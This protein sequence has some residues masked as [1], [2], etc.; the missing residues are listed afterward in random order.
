MNFNN[1]KT[2]LLKI[3]S[4]YED[5]ELYAK[6]EGCNLAGSIKDRAAQNVLSKLIESGILKENGTVI[7]SSSGNMGIALALY[8]NKFRLNFYCVVDPNINKNN[9]K[10][11]RLLGAHIIMVDEA[12]EHGGYLINRI[13][14]VK[15]FIEKNQ[16]AYWVNQYD[17]LLIIEGY[18]CIADEIIEDIK[19]LDYLFMTISSAG[20]IAGISRRIKQLSPNTKVVCVDVNGSV[21]FRN[22]AKKRYIPGA[23]SSIRPSNLEYACIDEVIFVDEIEA[24][25]MCHTF[26]E[27]NYLIGGSSGLALAGIK[28]YFEDN[29]VPNG[30]KVVT[31]FPDKG[32]SYIDTVYNDEWINEKYML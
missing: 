4:M 7:E 28:K 25:N 8:C 2:P 10:I 29:I 12:D 3:D 15:E 21:I 26:T 20:S 18:E 14:A 22:K 27:S 30:S 19:S 17:N 13:A 16:D 11:L 24:I 6:N 5:I 23:G 31:V 1:Y 9:L 32:D